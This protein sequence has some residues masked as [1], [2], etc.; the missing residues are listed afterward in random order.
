MRSF[1]TRKH[2]DTKNIWVLGAESA[3]TVA[4]NQEA[5]IAQLKSRYFQE[6]SRAWTDFL[7]DLQVAQA[8]DNKSAL[9]ELQALGTLGPGSPVFCTPGATID[10]GGLPYARLFKIVHCNTV[11]D[12]PPQSAADKVTG[13]IA[14]AAESAAAQKARQSQVGQLILGDA[15]APPPKPPDKTDVEVNFEPLAQFGYAPPPAKEGDPPTATP[16]DGYMNQVVAPVV[17]D[18]SA[19]STSRGK[20]IDAKQVQS[21]FNKAMDTT[22]QL[23]ATSRQNVFT[24]PI[25]EPLLENPIALGLQGVLNDLGGVAGGKWEPEVWKKWYSTLDNRYPFTDSVRDASLQDF[26]TFFKPAGGLLW[27]FYDANLATMLDKSGTFDGTTTFEPSVQM[28]QSVG[29]TPDF[30][31]CYNRGLQITSDSFAPKTETADIEFDINLH[32]VSENVSEVTFAIDGAEKKYQ[33]APEEWVHVS[34]PAKEP[35]ARGGL[36]R[37]RGFDGLDE[38]IERPGDFGFF[39]LLDAAVSIE[40]GTE[41]GRRN[42]APTVVVTWPLRSQN[43]V[44]RMD[45]KPATNDSVFSYHVQNHQR[46]FRGYWCPRLIAT[47]VR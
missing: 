8:R 15:G 37:I 44:V 29:F 45:I 40:A 30:L 46:V 18:L 34:W 6:Y 25:L 38:S 7:K 20:G 22:T 23:L 43:G 5:E 33:N 39:R 41:G 13:G 24:R 27:G 32:S 11:L 17:A 19:L 9:T 3:A 1:L 47:P 36:V 21:D 12:P 31:R 28:G 42:G 10:G 4:K 14:S 26:Q 16:F 35:K 2:L